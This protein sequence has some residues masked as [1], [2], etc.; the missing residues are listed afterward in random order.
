MMRV[1]RRWL[2]GGAA[3]LVALGAAL[4]APWR[5]PTPG[6]ATGPADTAI[7]SRSI[8]YFEHRLAI[9]PANYMVRSRLISRYVR[10]FTTGA[11]LADVARAEAEARELVRTGPDRTQ[12]LSRLS[13]V[14]LMQHKFAEALDAATEAQR[15]DSLSQ[16]ALG[17]EFDASL[18]AGRYAQAEAALDRL[19]PGT[20]D[21]QVRRAQW[22]DASGRSQAAYETFDRI[23]RQLQRSEA[24]SAVVA[25]CLTQMGG[26]AHARWGP[27]AAAAIWTRA[28]RVQPGYRFALEGLAGLAQAR[29]DLR[30]AG[31]LYA[32]IAAD[33]HP[34]LYLRLAEI[35]AAQ[36]EPDR[37]E[38]YER[39]FL[40]VAGAPAN[41]PLYGELLAIYYADMNSP[42]ARDTALALALRDLARRPT[43]ES[44]DVLSWVRFRRHELDEALAASDS[45]RR[46]GSP[47]PTMDWHRGRILAALGRQAEAEPLLRSASA[48][49]TLLA[50]HVRHDLD[51]ST[52]AARPGS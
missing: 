3:A 47:S 50:P 38:G 32:Q 9:Q 43:V 7:T 10:R 42:A 30:R 28:L 36:G 13:S 33:A 51:A 1:S 26:A 44:N 17:A 19:R 18:A 39:R 31:E 20:L 15:G 8:A 25:W 46:W 35:A 23:C 24:P 52:D 12:S 2:I 6:S 41:E 49:R 40:K 21:A 5:R 29:G 14:L 22:L 34:D 11:N 27:E 37:A 16:E 4:A 48:R 45:A